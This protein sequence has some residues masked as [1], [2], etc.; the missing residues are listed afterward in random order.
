M[1]GHQT[2][3][4]SLFPS[5]VVVEAPRKGQRNVHLDRRNEVLASRYYYHA[6]I[7]RRRYDDCLHH[8]EQE[9]F[10]TPSVIVQHLNEK[11]GFIKELVAKKTNITDLKKLYPHFVW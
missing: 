3:Y 7:L 11:T 5:S 10:I 6:Q 9:F 4:T 2:L 1:R 8:L